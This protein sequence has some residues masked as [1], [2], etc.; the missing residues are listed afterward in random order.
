MGFVHALL[1]VSVDAIKRAEDPTDPDS[2]TEAVASTNLDTIVGN[3]GWPG[4]TAPPFAAPN[5]TRTPMVGGQWRVQEDGGL[6]LVIV[7]NTDWPSIPAAGTIEPL[8]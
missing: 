6:D 8:N 2:L 3:V 7:E 1:E 5:V 4:K